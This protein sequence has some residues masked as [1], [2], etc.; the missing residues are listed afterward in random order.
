LS[1]RRARLSSFGW[2]PDEAIFE[3]ASRSPVIEADTIDMGNPINER[4]SS[5]LRVT[6]AGNSTDA[7]LPSD[8]EQ[9]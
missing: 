8:R 9:P 1:P 6:A 7:R 4:I 5:R 2:N 3:L